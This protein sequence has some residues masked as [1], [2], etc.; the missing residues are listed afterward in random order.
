MKTSSLWG[1]VRAAAAVA[2]LGWLWAGCGGEHEDFARK[3]E[4][5]LG[6]QAVLNTFDIEP[7]VQAFDATNVP[8]GSRICLKAGADGKRGALTIKNINPRRRTCRS[9]T[10]S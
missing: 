5:A 4:E 6:G 3:G 8:P 10:S 1:G 7:T 9:R 2:C